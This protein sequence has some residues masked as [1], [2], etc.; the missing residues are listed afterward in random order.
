[1][2]LSRSV[3]S[4][5]ALAVASS[6]VPLQAHAEV[7]EE[8]VVRA[9]L[10]DLPSARAPVSATVLDA[11]T[12]RG[13]GVNHFGDVLGLVPNLLQAGGTSRPRYF[14]LRGIGELEQYEGA[15]NPSVGFLIDGI[16]FSGVGMPAFLADLARVEVL[17]GPQGT[18]YG[19]N[20]L[21]G[22]VTLESRAP[23]GQ[24]E[25]Q[26]TAE[27]GDHGLRA[28]SL[29]LDTPLGSPDLALRLTAH[30]GVADGFRRNLF[31]GRDDTNGQDE[32]LLRG[33]LRWQPREALRLDL[34]AM[35][36][37]LDNGYD[38][39][40][41]DNS[42]N[43]RSDRP[44]EDDQRSLGLAARLAVGTPE[45][46]Q[47]QASTSLADSDIRYSFDGDWAN[48]A[49]WGANGPYDFFE[50][51][52]RQRR[53]L[54][55]DLRW[56]SP[57]GR[58]LRWVGGLYALRLD[59]D[60]Q[61]LDLY[62]GDVYRSLDSQ[63]H[64]TNLAAYGQLDL[65][66][67]T[68]WALSLGL[69]REQREA[70]YRDSNALQF[71]PTDRMTGG[72]ATLTRRWDESA[73]AYLSL[74]RG[75]KAG[76][77]NLA[78]GLPADLAQYA[79]EALW[80]IEAGLRLA[81]ELRDW[82]L[83]ASAFLMRRTDQQVSS[84]F[85]SDPQDPLTFVYLTDNAARGSNRGLELQGRWRPLAGLQLA[86]TLGLLDARFDRYVLDGRDLGGRDQAHAPSWQASL[87]A[88]YRHASGWFARADA[89]ATDGFYFSASHDQRARGYTLVNLRAGLAGEGWE[90][91]LW[92]RNV[93]DQRY[94]TRGFYFGNEPPDWTP[95]LYLYNGDPRAIGL[96]VVVRR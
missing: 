10:R 45:S 41:L 66:L 67:G 35:L 92:L 16:D 83:Q 77:F 20:A 24:H 78:A 95:K 1:M 62:N 42:R 37:D 87:S 38:A 85:Q 51:T 32:S 26:A 31:L 19:A 73:S 44:G 3:L 89:T 7:L 74:N 33:K 54:S 75:Y 96:R 68:R 11:A 84:S 72:H 52:A 47:W 53:T 93:F 81:G 58:P 39:W 15:P 40:A 61:L 36:A 69:R 29:V 4:S 23:R 2:H 13:A 71:A 88:D 55:Q 79:P 80:N 94:A 49:Y 56:L 57:T 60:Y 65:D 21:A 90:A 27:L 50:R 43:T 70:R 46:G 34:T 14:Q 91:S 5:I 6:L 48:D 28:G 18:A 17:R 63:Y 8:V 64:A 59:E 9:G 76:G 30:R 25:L 22:L 86:G 12:L 82:D